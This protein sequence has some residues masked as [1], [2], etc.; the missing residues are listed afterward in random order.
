MARSSVIDR[1]F[2][3]VDA[4]SI[5]VFRVAFGALMF[6]EVLR[7][8]T[9][10]WIARYYITSSFHFTYFGF[11]WL[12]PWP[13]SGMYWHFALL[14]VLSLVIAA[15]LCYR[16]AA[17]LFCAAFSYV[18]LLEQARYLNHFY[19]ICL[20]S[21][22][23]GWV[24]AHRLWSLDAWRKDAIRSDV[25]PA[26]TL[27]LLRIQIGIP[28]FYAGVAK[29][30]ADWLAGNPLRQW[31]AEGTRLSI[32]GPLFKSEAIVLLF[33][34]GS[35]AFDLLIVPLLLWPR[36]RRFAFGA[37]VLFHATNAWL[38]NIGIFPPL[39]IAAT[40]VFFDPAWP[41]QLWNR[42]RPAAGSR[43]DQEPEPHAWWSSSRIQLVALA[44]YVALQI[45]IPLRHFMY[46]G[47]VSWTEEGHRFS[48]H[49]K[50]RDKTG[51]VR[52]LVTDTTSGERSF[53]DP[54]IYLMGWQV[55]EMA[56]DPDMILQFCHHVAEDARAKNQRVQ[57]RAEA[58]VSLN[59]RPPEL[60]IDPNV[61][62][63]GEAR[64]LLPARWIL[65]LVD[66]VLAQAER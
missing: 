26:W 20:V 58:L 24:P 30:N 6:V 40:T 60:L 41:R 23:L 51:D 28:Y 45:L 13:G 47:D 43:P 35:V 1:A 64:S 34:Y 61:D 7:Y 37:A 54:H 8:F 5:A 59:G 55:E 27:W 2:Q 18:F 16:V 49:M 63:A 46:P 66:P 57:V 48:W 38:F 29:L 53:V 21:F 56:T 52:F 44:C 62:L 14:G 19:L 39:M 3:P 17:P 22:V 65:P 25:V 32:V 12:H 33:V 42:I 36:T 15:G 31:L 10:G 50:L 9:H 4:A 11:G